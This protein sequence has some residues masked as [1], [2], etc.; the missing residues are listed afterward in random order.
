[1]PSASKSK[2][3]FGGQEE[4]RNRIGGMRGHR[5]GLMTGVVP[6]TILMALLAMG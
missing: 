6:S 5:A 4:E 2:R 3:D 1:M